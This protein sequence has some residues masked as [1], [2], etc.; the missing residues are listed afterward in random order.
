MF[1]YVKAEVIETTEA[2]NLQIVR[3]RKTAVFQVGYW[4][5]SSMDE[6]RPSTRNSNPLNVIQ[7]LLVSSR[8]VLS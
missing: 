7:F 1:D 8:I 5:I 4:R 6:S 2:P 3:N